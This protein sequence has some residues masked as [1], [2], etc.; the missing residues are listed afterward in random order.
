MTES[1]ESQTNGVENRLTKE[2][3]NLL[4]LRKYSGPVYLISRDEQMADALGMLAGEETLG[5]DIEMKPSFHKGESYPP[6]L[7]QLATRKA[8]FLFQLKFLSS[9]QSLLAILSRPGVV[10]AGVAV[11]D[12][13]RRL[14]AVYS[15]QPAGFEELGKMAARV[16]LK[17]G[18]LRTLAANLLNFRVSKQ[19]Q[20][21]NWARDLLSPGQI[22]YAA[23]DAWVCRELYLFLK[24]K[25]P[26]PISG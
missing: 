26:R 9:I 17:D 11:A 24:K 13:V 16:G 20:R 3:I 18:G 4:P 15:F 14:R 7:I 23:T 10:K 21:S 6:A 22:E 8:V 1:M 5:F 2:Q 12:D 19:A 25:S